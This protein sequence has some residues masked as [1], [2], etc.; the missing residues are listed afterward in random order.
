VEGPVGFEP[1]TPGL[2]VRSSTAELRAP[3]SRIV[4]GFRDLGKR[5]GA[6]CRQIADK[7]PGTRR[8]ELV[9]DVTKTARLP[10]G[11]GPDGTRRDRAGRNEE[12]Y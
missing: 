7:L 9:R 12:N 8:D 2:K 5:Q 1:T 11:M 10:Y 3:A 6:T 4:S